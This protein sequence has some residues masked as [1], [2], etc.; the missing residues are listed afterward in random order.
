MRQRSERVHVHAGTWAIIALKGKTAK[1]TSENPKHKNLPFSGQLWLSRGSSELKG[2][3]FPACHTGKTPCC[4]PPTCRVWPPSWKPRCIVVPG[5]D[6]VACTHPSAPR[7]GGYDI[8]VPAHPPT[9]NKFFG[10]NVIRESVIS[11]SFD[12]DLSRLITNKPL[13]CHIT[14]T[15]TPLIQRSQCTHLLLLCF[16]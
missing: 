10:V 3:T 13:N 11:I 14:L 5:L 8:V 2:G 6:I 7:R 16:F 15:L 12:R 9:Y 1:T 4:W